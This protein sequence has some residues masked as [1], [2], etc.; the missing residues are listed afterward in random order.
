MEE[1]CKFKHWRKI[2]DM[3]LRRF[4]YRKKVNPKSF[5]FA[6]CA[7]KFLARNNGLP[8]VSIMDD[9]ESL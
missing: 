6:S 7:T 2:K 5:R 8:I 3:N 4:F 9:Y 1:I